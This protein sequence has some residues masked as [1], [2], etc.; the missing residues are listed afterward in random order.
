MPL[1]VEIK[2]K[3]KNLATIKDILMANQADFKGTDHQI[4]TYFKVTNGRMK[5]REGNIE[6]ALI[7]Y[8]RPDLV[9]PKKSNYILYQPQ[10]NSS[11]KELLIRA[12]GI[13]V[14]VD[15]LRSIF[16]IEN[17]KFHVDEVKN[18]GSFME[19]EA[20]DANDSIGEEKLLQQCQYYMNLLGISE[21]DLIDNSY[22]DLLLHTNNPH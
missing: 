22:S 13:L 11:L 5:F 12:N 9:G 3:C 21:S 15:K 2:A 6:N 8:D 18:L 17:V 1:N 20:I 7:H 4:D 19:I 10:A 14:V 16:F